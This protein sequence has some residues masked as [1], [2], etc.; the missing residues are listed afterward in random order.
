MI[1]Y[2]V[3]KV[4]RCSTSLPGG[5]QVSPLSL[6]APSDLTTVAL[7]PPKTLQDEAFFR[8]ALPYL[9]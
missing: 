1:K 9:F 7:T 8:I 2:D 3:W 5:N 4:E 6:P